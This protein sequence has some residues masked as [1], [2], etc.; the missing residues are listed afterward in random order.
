MDKSK[1][2]SHGENEARG[3]ARRREDLKELARNLAILS[4]AV[5][6]L[7]EDVGCGPAGRIGLYVQQGATGYAASESGRT[8][9]DVE[10]EVTG[11]TQAPV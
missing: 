1:Q 2:V 9:A 5:I 7:A 3:D 8:Y 4:E 11:R 10:A 6:A